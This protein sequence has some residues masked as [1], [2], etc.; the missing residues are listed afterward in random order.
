MTPLDLLSDLPIGPGDPQQSYAYARILLRYLAD[1]VHDAQ[2]SNGLPV[3]DVT[4][5]DMWLRETAEG[6]RLKL[7]APPSFGNHR[8]RMSG[9]VTDS[10]CPRC[11]HIHEGVGECGTQMGKD[12]LCRCDMEVGA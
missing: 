3:R 10:T 6:L 9:R 12:R 5:F 4:D 2:L 8:L 7:G 11:G 1:H